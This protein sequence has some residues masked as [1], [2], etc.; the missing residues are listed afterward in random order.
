MS[1]TEFNQYTLVSAF[2]MI[3]NKPTVEVLGVGD[4]VTVVVT[5][6]LVIT[7]EA[8][9]ALDDGSIWAFAL[10]KKEDGCA[11]FVR[12]EKA[13]WALASL[14]NMLLSSS[15]NAPVKLWDIETRR[16]GSFLFLATYK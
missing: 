13:V 5:K 16:V 10:N 9:L 11:R 1:V 4:G 6:L 2:T 12:H 3:Q 7:G 15:V 14:E 8:F